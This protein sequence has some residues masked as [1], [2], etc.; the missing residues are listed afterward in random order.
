MATLGI[1]VSAADAA[2]VDFR[3]LLRVR[4]P[5]PFLLIFS[6]PMIE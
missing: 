3:K 6:L 1:I 5:E 2:A 4:P